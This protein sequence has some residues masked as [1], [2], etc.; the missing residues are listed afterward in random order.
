MKI[1]RLERETILPIPIEQAW[2]FFS[3][4]K[5]LKSITPPY[6]GF[7]I[8]SDVADKMY[9]GQIIVY[10][11]TPLM[12][13]PMKWVTEISHVIEGELFVDEQRFGPYSLWHH[14]HFFKSVPGGT[15]MVDIVDYKL[16]FGLLGQIMHPIIVKGKLEEIFTY[17]TEKMKEL[18]GEVPMTKSSVKREAVTA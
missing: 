17:R 5:N 12:G 3:S 16:P 14:K 1:Y 18:F 11:V 15:H 10:T 4:P 8:H 13:I 7:D 6:M 9:P 2:D